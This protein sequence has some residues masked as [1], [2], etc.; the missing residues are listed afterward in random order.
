MLF[1]NVLVIISLH[2]CDWLFSDVLLLTLASLAN[3]VIS[4]EVTNTQATPLL[5][6]KLAL[7]PGTLKSTSKSTPPRLSDKL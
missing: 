2:K 1:Y 4:C 7:P 6:V 3:V 5:A